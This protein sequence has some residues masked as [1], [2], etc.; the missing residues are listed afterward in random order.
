MTL[1]SLNSECYR[2]RIGKSFNGKLLVLFGLV[3]ADANKLTN[4]GEFIADAC[5]L[6][7]SKLF[8]IR[9]N[10]LTKAGASLIDIPL[11]A[12]NTQEV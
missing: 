1:H 2:R 3:D 4:T 5:P 10:G 8:C 11:I 7:P 12:Q 9:W 6:R